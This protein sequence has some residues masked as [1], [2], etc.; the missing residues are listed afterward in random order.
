MD[1]T[2][3]QQVE[4]IFKVTHDD[5]ERIELILSAHNAEPEAEMPPIKNPYAEMHG[6]VFQAFRDG[7]KHQRDADMAWLP[8]HDQQ[9]RKA[10]INELELNIKGILIH[11]GAGVTARELFNEIIYC[12]RAMAEEE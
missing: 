6:E 3:K 2:F 7:S 10:I 12:I 9:V 8:A 4:E 5:L 11:K 1:K